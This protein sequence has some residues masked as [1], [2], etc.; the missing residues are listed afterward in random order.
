MTDFIGIFLLLAGFVIGHGAVT[1]IDVHAFLGRTSG[2]WTEATTRSHKI[3]K[4]LIWLGTFLAIA[5]GIITFQNSQ[6]T[7]QLTLAVTA[8]ILIANGSFLTFYVSPILLQRE[9]AGK[10]TQL[11]PQS[12]QRATFVSF[13]ISL[14][15]WWAAL[16]LISQYFANL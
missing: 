3:T 1:V 12:L 16:V 14:I 7:L 5:G 11:L 8:I 15:G 2:Y 10:Q 9:R 6:P 13:I 4:P